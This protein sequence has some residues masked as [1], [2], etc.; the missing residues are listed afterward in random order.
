MLELRLD[1]PER[2][3]ALNIEMVAGLQ[4]AVRDATAQGI[5]VLLIRGTG[6][7][8]CSG[9]DLKDRLAMSFE[10]RLLHNTAI[11]DAF[12]ELAAAPFVTIAVLNGLAYGGGCEL[13]LACDMRIAAAGASIGLTENRI[14]TIPAAGGTQRLPRIIGAARALELILTGEPISADREAAIGLVNEVVEP[15]RL[16]I[17][18]HELAR[19]LASKSPQSIRE[20]KA[21]V[22][23]ANEMALA[24]GLAQERVVL[25]RIFASKDYAGGLAAFAEKRTPRFSDE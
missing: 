14:G 23:G 22:Y 1:R 21:L 25:H 10:Q 16:D 2:L 4:S 6:R 17:R 3:N 11:N 20:A 19:L 5:R 12:N 15:A 24:Q 13:A 8:F 18:A 7:A 9:A